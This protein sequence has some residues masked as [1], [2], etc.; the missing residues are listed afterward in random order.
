MEVSIV[1]SELSEKQ[2][3]DIFEYYFQEAGPRI[4]RRIINKIIDRVSILENYP[5]SGTKEELLKERAED[6]R[7]L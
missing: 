5:L 4:A 6:F 2:L 1:W 7:Y 3:K